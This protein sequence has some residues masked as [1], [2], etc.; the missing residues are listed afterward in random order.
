MN[1]KIQIIS[2]ENRYFNLDFENLAFSTI[3]RFSALE[4]FDYTLIDLNYNKLWNYNKEQ[5]K[6][7][8]DINI[9]TLTD[10]IKENDKIII[11]LPS[12][13]EYKINDTLSSETKQI[14]N[15]TAIITKFLNDY[16]GIEEITLAYGVNETIINDEEIGSD[17]YFQ[18]ISN[19]K[20]LT[21]NIISKPTTIQRRNYV[22]TTI[23]LSYGE[24]IKNFINQIFSPSVESIPDWF[25]EIEMFDDK[26]Q[27]L[28]I[29]EN[30]DKIKSL[31]E[32]ITTAEN[33]LKENNYYKSILYKQG[34]PLVKVVF[35]MLE[36]MLNCDLSK[37]KDVYKEDF[38]LEFDDVTFI[39]EIKGV[40]SNVKNR[41][42]SQ[43]DDHVSDR[44][45]YLK[46]NNLEENIKPLL[47]ENT[48]IETKPSERE[49]VDDATIE[50][51]KEKYQSLIITSIPFLELYQSFK[52][53]EITTEEIKNRF[54]DEIGLFK[55]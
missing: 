35:K 29:K 34:K 13:K 36:E 20:I 16:F 11:I 12:N 32:D 1:Y 8:E 50:K 5:S 27:K 26:E 47:I 41:H 48:F 4:A 44:E 37:F 55:P 7:E 49:E 14:K 31:E 33:K 19:F 10:S 18:D 45:D 53:G 51:A 25:D 17:F 28:Q 24:D 2:D 21:K 43:L 38:L 52:N 6:F 46:E 3:N 15:D 42:L 39:G 23:Q 40:N 9:K 54:K 22:L 30:E